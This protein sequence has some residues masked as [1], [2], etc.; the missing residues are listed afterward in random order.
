MLLFEYLQTVVPLLTP[1]KVKVHLARFNGEH[2]PLTVYIAGQFDEWQ[3]WQSRRNFERP[4]VVSLIQAK[5]LQRWL[6]AGTFTVHGSELVQAPDNQN[7]FQRY[8]LT[9]MAEADEYAGRI[10][11]KS[12]YKE[13]NSYPNGETLAADLNITEIT[14]QRLSVGDFPGYKG[15]CLTRDEL[16]II[17]EQDLKDWRRALSTIKGIYLLTDRIGGKLYVGQANGAGGIW[18]RWTEYFL[19]GHGG[20]VA[21]KQEL[22]I[23]DEERLSG[24]TF[25]LLEVMD[26]NSNG[27]EIYQRESHWKRILL[28]RENGYNRN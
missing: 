1:D 16:R 3:R 21:M 2:D 11:L 23:A 27:E 6:Y 18:Q 13:R 4:Y 15:L 20:N 8:N 12:V 5:H 19:S 26:I 28:S 9:R 14:P 17:I 10:Y 7:M 22:G 25:S 24:I